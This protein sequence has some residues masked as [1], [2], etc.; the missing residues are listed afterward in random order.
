[1][2]GAGKKLKS[3]DGRGRGTAVEGDIPA[4]GAVTRSAARRT[5]GKGSTKAESSRAR[6]RARR[7]SSSEDDSSEEEPEETDAGGDGVP[8]C[9]PTTYLPKKFHGSF[10]S[11]K[12]AKVFSRFNDEKKDLVR[13]IGLGGLLG[14]RREMN[15]SR[16]LIF[17]LVKQLNTDAMRLCIPDRPEIYLTDQ[18]VERVLGIKS[19]G[20]PLTDGG[21]ILSKHVRSKLCKEF[22]TEDES[23]LPTADDCKKIMLRRNANQM[24]D[25]QWQ[26]FVMATAAY[27][28]ACML[29][30]ED[31]KAKVPNGVWHLIANP[32]L[33]RHCN[34]AAYVLSVIKRNAL[35]IQSNLLLHPASIRL[36]G[37]WLYLKLMYL[38][39]V[40]LG[41]YNVPLG[42]IPRVVAYNAN[43]VKELVSMDEVNRSSF[44]SRP[45]RVVVGVHEEGT[46]GHGGGKCDGSTAEGK[47]AESKRAEASTSN[48]EQDGT[49][50]VKQCLRNIEHRLALACEAAHKENIRLFDSQ[51]SN[52]NSMF[53][54]LH[55]MVRGEVESMLSNM[56]QKSQC[57]RADGMDDEE[58]AEDN[59]IG[60]PQLGSCRT[61]AEECH[62]GGKATSPD[63][64]GKSLREGSRGEEDNA[65]QFGT[66]T[67]YGNEDS[68]LRTENVGEGTTMPQFD[69]TPKN[70]CGSAA[71]YDSTP[72]PS[73]Q[74]FDSSMRHGTNNYEILPPTLINENI[75]SPNM[76]ALTSA[77][78]TGSGSTTGKEQTTKGRIKMGA[79]K[80]KKD[81]MVAETLLSEQTTQG[82]AKK[83]CS[84]RTL[85]DSDGAQRDKTDGNHG[86]PLHERSSKRDRSTD[87]GNEEA[88]HQIPPSPFDLKYDLPGAPRQVAYDKYKY[89]MSK[90]GL[91]V[92]S[93]WIKV[94][95]PKLLEVTGGQVQASFKDDG[96]LSMVVMS[97]IVCLLQ[98]QDK[99]MYIKHGREHKQWRYFMPP[100]FSELALGSAY[101]GITPEVRDM[102]LGLEVGSM[103]QCCRMLAVPSRGA[104][105]W[106][107][108][109]WDLKEM[110]LHVF[111]PVIKEKDAEQMWA[112]HGA[113]IGKIAKAL[114]ACAD[115]FFKRWRMNFEDFPEQ[116][117]VIE[118]QPAES[119]DS[120]LYIVHY[121]RWFNGNNVVQPISKKIAKHMRRT[122]P[123]ELLA[124]QC[125]KG[126][127]PSD[128]VEAMGH[129]SL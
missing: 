126:K 73:A 80:R 43:N 50:I 71:V 95:F 32:Q 7:C 25:A 98:E 46:S 109:M 9:D 93:V 51:E 48:H 29:G 116:F 108:Y 61:Q 102:F 10:S 78:R 119:S 128:V 70:V 55:N 1:M 104:G 110:L 85:G 86:E 69:E 39:T 79:T 92:Q 74:G 121:M 44:G 91:E 111:D 56:K 27:C 37:C 124:M 35:Q 82:M 14:M 63:Q 2:V 31:R 19:T 21:R 118:D 123:Y 30:P 23:V 96:V 75:P 65:E 106:S 58:Q 97:G 62:N 122:L 26:T 87:L 66:P 8:T 59:V 84:H 64:H 24:T 120:G 125:N 15:H 107:L 41:P 33:L 45:V 22:R 40:D 36:G 67:N 103:I 34:W 13:S 113:F 4:E 47:A 6:A 11:N 3:R 94:E 20:I 5:R 54:G 72:V 60:E 52:I 57:S 49:E 77:R 114:T 81:G 99:S 18:S 16:H 28:C 68:I 105:Y 100:E 129:P 53:S 12:V 89:I 83:V 38:D 101:F 76:V 127:V 117:F 90:K 112:L 42:I 115:T 88:H 17:W